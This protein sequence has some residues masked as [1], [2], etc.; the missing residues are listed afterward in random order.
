MQAATQQQQI[1][2]NI[3]DMVPKYSG[4]NALRMTTNS[5]GTRESVPDWR[6]LWKERYQWGDS[7][8]RRVSIKTVEWMLSRSHPYPIHLFSDMLSGGE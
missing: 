8:A 5:G 7:T 6:P 1:P 4:D 3:V 2:T